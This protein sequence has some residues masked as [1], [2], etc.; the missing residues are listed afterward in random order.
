MELRQILLG[1]SA[2][3]EDL[4]SRLGSEAERSTHSDMSSENCAS[5]LSWLML[6]ERSA[7]LAEERSLRSVCCAINGSKICVYSH[8]YPPPEQGH[9]K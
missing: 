4:G 3:C 5:L 1:L 2:A 6:T 8:K 7:G 9:G